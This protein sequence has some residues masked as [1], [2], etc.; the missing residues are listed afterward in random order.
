MYNR[1]RGTIDLYGDDM[2]KIIYIENK[3]INQCRLCGFSEIRTPIFEHINVFTRSIGE[4]SD[5]VKKEFYNFVDKGGREIALRPEGT[6]SVIRAVV[7][8][9][10]LYKMPLPLRFFYSGPMFRYERPQSGRLRQFNQIGCELIAT[11]SIFDDAMILLLAVNG[12]NEIGIKKYKVLINNL[13]SFESRKKWISALVVYFK[14]YKNKLSELSQQRLET[15]PTRI[16]DDKID[17]VKDFVKKA[18]KLDKFLTEQEKKDFTYLCKLLDKQGIKYEIDSTLVRGLDYYTNFVFEIVSTASILSGQSTICGGGRYGKLISE[19]GDKDMSCVG[20]AWGISRL[21]VALEDE[22][23][24]YNVLLRSNVGVFILDAKAKE[25]GFDVYNQMLKNKINCLFF[26]NELKIS[27]V[28]SQAQK[29][30]IS[31]L[32]LIG[33]KELTTKTLTIKDFEMRTEN[34]ISFNQLS[35]AIQNLKNE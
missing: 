6:A 22:K 4:M 33:N 31:K 26:P 11:D 10:M 32:I 12:I 9:K 25:Y 30:N 29:L 27:K 5:I 16:L 15:N 17:G 21:V 3:L 7:E 14:K 19:F 8:D 34:T 24:N 2:N 23:I 1:P 18:P 28:F 20:F 13:G 35:K